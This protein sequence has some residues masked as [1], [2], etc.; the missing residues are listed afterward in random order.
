MYVCEVNNHILDTVKT[1]ILYI[2]VPS[3]NNKIIIMT[4]K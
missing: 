3:K 4:L 2:S 1:L